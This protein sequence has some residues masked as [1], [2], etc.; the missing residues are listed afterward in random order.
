[1]GA[2]ITVDSA[3]LM[4]KGLEVIEAH[5]AF[6]VSYENIKVLIHPQAILHSAAE[7][8][9]GAVLAQLGLPDMKLPIAYAFTWPHR[10]PKTFECLGLAFA[11]GQRG[12]LFPAALSAA[13]EEAVSQFLE[14]KIHFTEIPKVVKLV[15][16]LA[17]TEFAASP[18]APISLEDVLQADAWARQAAKTFKPNPSLPL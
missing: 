12:G 16:K 18:T 14:Q 4:N 17:E 10:L 15:L 8:Q 13:N 11:A 6:G 7:M 2:K 3:S 5:E 1:M 9:D